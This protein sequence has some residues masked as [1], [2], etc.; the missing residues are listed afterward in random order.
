LGSLS[1]VRTASHQ[2]RSIV[3]GVDDS[4]YSRV[5]AA[6][7]T[8]LAERLASRLVVMHVAETGDPAKVLREV[9]VAENAELAVVG[10]RAQS[11]RGGLLR[12]ATAALGS[13]LPCPIIAVPAPTVER[14]E[15]WWG[16][17]PASEP[18][19]V[20]GI[21]DSHQALRSL[22]LAADMTRRLDGVLILVHACEDVPAAGRRALP[23]EFRQRAH[24]QW[25]DGQRLLRESAE[26]AAEG[27]GVEP[28]V[29]I[30]ARDALSSLLDAA[31][32]E[33]A[34][35]LAVGSRGHGALRATLHGSFFHILVA[36]A[37]VPVLAVPPSARLM[38]G[39]RFYEVALA[40]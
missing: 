39:G 4:S 9:A 36:S 3:C 38:M 24:K 34:D 6:V 13:D 11:P 12:S 22:L 16:E 20:C 30:H 37:P 27:I 5:A 28:Q 1:R 18:R 14:G 10:Y 15:E 31:K 33:N 32:A 23:P 25:Q 29:R 40:T 17:W 21:D 2:S 8:R 35:L 19:V 26:I 7:A